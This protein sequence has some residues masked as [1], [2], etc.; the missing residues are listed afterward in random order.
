MNFVEGVATGIVSALLIWVFTTHLIPT[1][2]RRLHQEAD[3]SGKWQ[4]YSKALDAP[5][6]IAKV[7]QRGEGVVVELERTHGESQKGIARTLKYRGHLRSD[8]LC[9]LFEDSED[10]RNIVG[11]AVL[12]LSIDRKRLEGMRTY[13]ER[14]EGASK[15]GEVVS[16][17]LV[18][19]KA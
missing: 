15:Y 12:K 11:A 17:P 5:A 1:M 4:Y 3:I 18:L 16:K 13:V 7:T 19:K 10:L 6:G 14:G 2:I 9:L 8:Q